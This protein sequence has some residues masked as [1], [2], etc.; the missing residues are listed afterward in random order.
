MVLIVADKQENIFPLKTF[1]EINQFSVDTALS[2]QEAL[3]KVL[4]NNYALII[5][6]VEMHDM[7]GIEVAEK[8]SAFKKVQNIPIIFLSWG[9]IEKRFIT[10]DYASGGIE[11]VLKPFDPDILLLK[12]QTLCK[13]YEQTQALNTIHAALKEEIETGKQVEVK[14]KENTVV[15]ES[16]LNSIHQIVFTVKPS[17][18][19]EYV[20]K[21]WYNYSPEMSVFP[22][23]PE[24][25]ETFFEL[26]NKAL[27]QREQSVAEVRIKKLDT[28][29]FKYH[30]LKMSP[31]KNG[32]EIIKWIGILT[33][34]NEQKMIPE[35]VE[36]MVN[37][38]TL[39]LQKANR[40]LESANNELKQFAWVVTHDLQEPLRKIQTFSN[41]VKDNYLQD[42]NKAACY[43][44]K[45]LYSSGRM[46]TLI[47]D[48]LNYTAL[49]G[50]DS[51]EIM[52]LNKVVEDVLQD[53][54]L[55][56]RE[57]EAT[58]NADSLP[59]I[60][61]VPIQAT[62]LFQNII[63]NALKYAKHNVPSIINIK[64]ELL[65]KGEYKN[66]LPQDVDYCRITISDNGIGFSESYLDKIFTVFQ[67][68]H[69][70]EEYEGTG[71][72]LAIVKKIIDKHK[73]SITAKSKENEGAEFIIVLPVNQ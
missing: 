45:V 15:F 72:G 28:D 32:G 20:N 25:S 60:K 29:E 24:G 49:S 64:S 36:K 42:D 7:D 44:D 19:I 48:L 30:S 68:L 71:I 59:A 9:N 22:Q 43:M 17:G 40:E 47:H 50:S 70:K 57:K 37:E 3:Q 5:L 41:I 63:G 38:R 67:R 56:I 26:L 23:T 11:Y 54:E 69:K 62:Q 31:I 12:V 6:D 21:Y 14:L 65:R 39:A 51:Y 34:I 66:G 53:L 18:C 58:I 27:L 61:M 4:K 8:L 1:L 33:D 46:T 16:I 73:G 35:L 10:K 55:L 52:D 13:L 2:G